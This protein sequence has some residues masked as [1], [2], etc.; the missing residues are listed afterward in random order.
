LPADPLAIVHESY[1]AAALTER[2]DLLEM[3]QSLQSEL[4]EKGMVFNKP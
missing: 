1:G 2:A 4:T 3:D